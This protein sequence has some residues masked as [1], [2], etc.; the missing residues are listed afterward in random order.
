MAL[1]APTLHAG[2]SYTWQQTAGGETC[3]PGSRAEPWRPRSSAAPW[4]SPGAQASSVESRGPHS[5]LPPLQ[6]RAEEPEEKTLTRFSA[7]LLAHPA[8]FVPLPGGGVALS[9]FGAHTSPSALRTGPP[10]CRPPFRPPRRARSP[11]IPLS[12][13]FRAPLLSRCPL[14]AL[15]LAV[16]GSAVRLLQ[17]PGLPPRTWGHRETGNSVT[18]ERERCSPRLARL[19]RLPR[20]RTHS[21][22]SSHGCTSARG[23]L[24]GARRSRQTGIHALS[25]REPSRASPR[26]CPRCAPSPG[27]ARGSLTHRCAP[28]RLP[29][30]SAVHER[31][32]ALT[33]A[34]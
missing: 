11:C 24:E 31:R 26:P 10:R 9:G 23:S 25:P 20:S 28:L 5:S 17:A 22:H 16:P 18:K 21:G 30:L 19:P 2:F 33:Q 8:G 32:A 15:E 6:Q 1:P 12:K 7:T 13:L 3:D 29:A 34:S 27:S 4:R 14:P